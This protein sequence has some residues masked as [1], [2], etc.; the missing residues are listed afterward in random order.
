MK[1]Y[2]ESSHAQNSV[3]LRRRKQTSF[4]KDNDFMKKTKILVSAFL[5]GVLV[6]VAGL[7]ELLLRDTFPLAA[8]LSFGAALLAIST[9]NLYLYTAKAGYLLWD[10]ATVGKR[11]VH[12]LFAVIGNVAGAGAV[13]VA[14]S[15]VYSDRGFAK[16]AVAERFNIDVTSAAVSALLCG[17]LMFV[18]VHGYRRARNEVVGSLVL[19]GAASAIVLCGFEHSITDVFFVAFTG[20]SVL[21]GLTVAGIAVLG[22][23]V[24][25]VLFELLYE[26]KKSDSEVRR[27]Q[28][29]EAEVEASHRRHHSHHLTDDT[30]N[31]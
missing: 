24:G 12:L 16:E 4:R 11:V 3:R 8:A 21:R 28:E 10:S 23:L 5:T 22:N 18:A 20:E 14:L 17:V 15:L 1:R 7:I 29:A 9:L 2:V 30:E 19:L 26:Y 31:D 6:G 25:A 27:E 13:G